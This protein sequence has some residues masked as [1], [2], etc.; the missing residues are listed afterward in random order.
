MTCGLMSGSDY[1]ISAWF[2]HDPFDMGCCGD[3]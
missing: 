2:W 3:W 1:T